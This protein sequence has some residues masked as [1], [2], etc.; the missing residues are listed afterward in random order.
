[1]QVSLQRAQRQTAVP[2]ELRLVQSAR[3]E[4]INQAF[5]FFPTASFSVTPSFV[6]PA[7]RRRIA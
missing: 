5:N 7:P 3:F 4:F 1:M 6:F 2:A